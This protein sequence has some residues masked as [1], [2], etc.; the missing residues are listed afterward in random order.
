MKD[1]IYYTNQ[2][3]DVK[4]FAVVGINVVRKAAHYNLSLHKEYKFPALI[5]KDKL[6]CMVCYVGY[7]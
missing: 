2:M 4:S 5:L 3:R 6:I 7:V 1:S